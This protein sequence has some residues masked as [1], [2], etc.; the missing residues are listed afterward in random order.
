MATE[1]QPEVHVTVIERPSTEGDG[2]A[3]GNDAVDDA[4]KIVDMATQMA[5]SQA[6]IQQGGDSRTHQ[7][8]ESLLDATNRNTDT[9]RELIGKTEQVVSAT[10]MAVVA[11]ITEIAADAEEATEIGEVVK[12]EITQVE[13]KIEESVPVKRKSRFF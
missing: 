4:A 6:A 7:L 2:Y 13:S 8:L 9:L 12:E 5:M 10:E 11:E 1:N 3:A